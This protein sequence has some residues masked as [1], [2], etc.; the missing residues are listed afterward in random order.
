VYKKIDKGTKIE[1]QGATIWIPPLGFGCHSVTQEIKPVDIIKR[2]E[3]PEEQYWERQ[4]LPDDYEDRLDIE[5]ERQETE[6]TY[7]DPYLDA[8][9]MREWHRRL[10][11]VWFWN[12]GE[13]VYLTGLN[14]F[15]LNYWELDSKYPNYRLVDLEYFYFWQRC[16]HDPKCYGMIEVTR[17]RQGKTFRSACML[18]ECVSR[19]ER[20]LG[21]IQSKD[22]DSAEELF[23]K[24]IVP[25][26]QGLPEFFVPVWDSAAGSTPKTSL[27]FYKPSK[28]GKGAVK[29]MRGPELKS[30]INY[31]SAK[32]KAYDGTKT[33]RLLLDESG[34][35]EHDVIK[36]HL[37]VKPCCEDEKRNIV[38]KMIVT[39]TVEELGIK[40]KFGDLWEWSDQSNL[41][42]NG[43][44]KSGL[45]RFF[46]PADRAGDYD[47]YGF[48]FTEKN[49]QEL[50]AERLTLQDDPGE[51]I[52]QIRKFPLTWEE[53]F[54]LSNTESLYNIVAI[55]NRISLLS[56]Y[57]PTKFGN[58]VWKDG[59]KN[60][61]VEWVDDPKGRW[62][63][64]TL[65]PENL[66]NRVAI[67]GMRC[68][69]LNKEKFSAGADPYQYNSVTG[70]G[71]LGTVFL[72]WKFSIHNQDSPFNGA[73]IIRY[74]N[75]PQDITI[76]YDDVVKTL[77]FHGAELL[78]ERN[79][80]GL[81]DYMINNGYGDF[82]IYLKGQKEP[83][84]YASADS[85]TE[86]VR[87][88]EAYLNKHMD[89]CFFI[90]TLEQQIK[91]ELNATEKYDEAMGFGYALMTDTYVVPRRQEQPNK[92]EVTQLIRQYRV[93][94]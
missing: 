84:I 37:I 47:K 87:T 52:D 54:K 35:V 25:Q 46:M 51:L 4:E 81:C 93:P 34:K 57:K 12:N 20:A 42:S 49:R 92:I 77:W 29:H 63:I 59:I 19:M 53:A 24:A 36:R 91:F 69:P 41:N 89:K 88:T 71:S 5:A 28:K 38:G 33:V 10:Y 45:Y 15:Y 21:G 79:K 48:P 61:S 85:N 13:P 75:R 60:S 82:L 62:E 65:I 26:F 1:I 31:K 78:A 76:Y 74:A 3:N 6:P 44:T 30:M 94:A 83:G 43:A 68:S 66:R 72:K 27:R 40:F 55:N 90:K 17:R 2:S 14:Y 56:Q 8:I 11:G 9:R 7:S 18:Y 32:P 50:E 23:S 80:F 64:A 86:L 58:Y 73:V 70:K 16:V 22:D 67:N 39:S